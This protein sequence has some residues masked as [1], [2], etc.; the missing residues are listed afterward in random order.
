MPTKLAYNLKNQDGTPVAWGDGCVDLHPQMK[1]HEYFKAFMDERLPHINPESPPIVARA[2]VHRWMRDYIQLLC[3]SVVASI[4]SIVDPTANWKDAAIH[5]RFTVPGS[6]AELPTVANFR[7]LAEGAIYHCIGDRDGSKVITKITEARAAAHCLLKYGSAASV[8]GYAAGNTVLSCDIGGATTDIAVSQIGA[9]GLLKIP[10]QL[11]M[12]LGGLADIDRRFILHA[13]NILN[14]AGVPNSMEAA[15]ILSRTEF[16]V[17]KRE[18]TGKQADNWVRFPLLSTWEAS[19][20]RPAGNMSST[21]TR[22]DDG[23]EG[24]QLLIHV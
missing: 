21:G 9:P 1:V 19:V 3:G 14:C 6:W 22:I 10:K 24:K 20:W 15:Q 13:Q 16:R 17:V 5:W 11:G 2:N 4:D 12:H 8:D 18:F 23:K 7:R